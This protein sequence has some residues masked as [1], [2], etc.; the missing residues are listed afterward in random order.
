MSSLEHDSQ[1]EGPVVH[2]TGPIPETRFIVMLTKKV[3]AL[4]MSAALVLG[5][6]PSFGLQADASIETGTNKESTAQN[7]KEAG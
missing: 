6:I 2:K 3:L 1:R 7:K 4:L 5:D